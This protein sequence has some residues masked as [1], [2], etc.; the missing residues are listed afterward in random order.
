MIRKSVPVHKTVTSAFCARVVPSSHVLPFYKLALRLSLCDTAGKILSE[1]GRVRERVVWEV[2]VLFN[3][4]CSRPDNE[5][6]EYSYLGLVL[7][8]L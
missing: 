6:R 4:I 8:L 3:N 7:Y 1:K 2:A 5:Y